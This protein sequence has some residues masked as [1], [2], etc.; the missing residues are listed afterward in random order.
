MAVIHTNMPAT[1]MSVPW[2]LSPTPPPSGSQELQAIME[3][4][5]EKKSGRQYGPPGRKALVFFIDDLNMP[6]ADKY[7][8]QSA[9]AL[10]RQ[11]L[12]YK[13]WYDRQRLTVKEILNVQYLASMNH[14]VSPGTPT[15]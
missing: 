12:D 10:L 14:K 5:L 9:I 6:E 3:L 4:S 11:H 1:I 8:T 13:F 7:G 15:A 2:P